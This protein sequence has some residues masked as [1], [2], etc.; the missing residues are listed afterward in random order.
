MKSLGTEL[1]DQPLD[2]S[3]VRKPEDEQPIGP[4]APHEIAERSL[5]VRHVLQHI[6]ADDDVEVRFRQRVRFDV[7]EYL[8][9]DGGV[10]IELLS[11]YV[12]PEEVRVGSEADAATGTT[13][14]IQDPERTRLPRP[15]PVQERLQ[16]SE[17]VRYGVLRDPELSPTHRMPVLPAISNPQG[18]ILP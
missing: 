6:P 7:P 5:R 1:G 10:S 3:H 11:R 2:G 8:L 18:C 13:P 17:V 14:R 12:D 16:L 4:N 15:E 9:V